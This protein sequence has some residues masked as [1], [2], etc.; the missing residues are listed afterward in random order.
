LNPAAHGKRKKK[1]QE[2]ERKEAL[3]LSSLLLSGTVRRAMSGQ[4]WN[5]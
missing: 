4:Q 5:P 1:I 3:R 2:E